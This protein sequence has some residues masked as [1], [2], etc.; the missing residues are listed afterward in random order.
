MGKIHKN[1]QK[2]LEIAGL[3]VICSKAQQQYQ[4]GII[5]VEPIWYKWQQLHRAHNLIKKTYRK[6]KHTFNLQVQMSV[7]VCWYVN[8]WNPQRCKMSVLC[9]CV[10]WQSPCESFPESWGIKVEWDDKITWVIQ[11]KRERILKLGQHKLSI[12]DWIV[13]P[14]WKVWPVTYRSIDLKP[15]CK[16]V[17]D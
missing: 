1:V 3:L 14:V 12:P 4:H 7:C 16:D 10:R 13:L 8:L 5:D 17:F 6:E 11:G 15:K 9:S 2:L